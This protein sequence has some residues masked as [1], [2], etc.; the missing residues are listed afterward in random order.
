MKLA[1]ATKQVGNITVERYNIVTTHIW[2]YG[3][4]EP[5]VFLDPVRGHSSI[6]HLDDRG[7]MGTVGTGRLPPELEALPSGSWK[8]HE[9][10]K[11]W[12]G[13]EYARACSDL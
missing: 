1:R 6:T 9:A 8:R 7:W 12:R 10:V 4:L 11:A 5:T 2:V 3:A 13:A